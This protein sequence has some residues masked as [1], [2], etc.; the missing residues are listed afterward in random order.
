MIYNMTGS[1][2]THH[3]IY[4]SRKEEM[5]EGS[6]TSYLFEKG[7]DKILKKVGEECTDHSSCLERDQ[8]QVLFSSML[9]ARLSLF[10]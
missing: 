1:Q 8:K 4:K 3:V 5:P 6:Y 9:I 2:F 10:I 7:I